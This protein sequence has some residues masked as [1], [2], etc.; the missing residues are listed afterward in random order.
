MKKLT[1][2]TLLSLMA[3]TGCVG[4]TTQED[5]TQEEQKLKIVCPTGAPAVAFHK[6][7][8]NENFITNSAPTNII[9]YFTTGDAD[10]IVMDTTNGIQSLKKGANYKIAATITLGNFYLVSTSEGNLEL[11]VDDIVV[12]FGNANAV[13]YKMFSYLYG[14]D[15]TV[16]YTSGGVNKA[17]ATL[18]SGV[19]AATGHKADW[20]FIAEPYLY[21]AQHNESS[22][23]YGKNV[24]IINIQEE[25]KKKATN[26]PLMQASVFIKNTVEKNVGDKF[27]DSL[28][29]D[30]EDAI[31][32][33]VAMMNNME[34]GGEAQAVE[35]KYG[36]APATA[37]E[38]MKT[39]GLGLGFLKSIDN[40]SAIDHYLSLFGIEK[41][42]ATNIW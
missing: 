32:D 23:I 36:V 34:K 11:D 41:T 4:Q 35:A 24:P 10:V 1:I 9:P 28:K 5:N 18:T 19:N 29:K 14:E 20:V 13:P 31:A 30:I 17:A 21:Q 2:F 15:Y 40:K 26:L 42:D 7:A 8:S 16:E 37:K 33:P 25:Y 22:I 39:N 6:Y 3:L 27:L 38:V 12:L